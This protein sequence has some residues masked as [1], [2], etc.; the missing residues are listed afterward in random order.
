MTNLSK[1]TAFLEKAYELFPE[2]SESG[3]MTREQLFAVRKAG[4]TVPGVVWDNR[5]A[6]AKPALYVIPGGS[7]S[8]PVS[9]ETIVEEK[10]IVQKS[11]V[12]STTVDKDEDD[13][14]SYF[15][16]LAES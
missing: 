4:I 7:I 9:A 11:S 10:V 8:K 15:Q 12:V 16:K 13:A 5:V 6:G 1:E 14:L 3:Q 2:V